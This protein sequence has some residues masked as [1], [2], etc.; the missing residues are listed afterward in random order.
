MFFNVLFMFFDLYSC[1]LCFVSFCA[2][3]LLLFCLCPIFVPVYRPLTPAGNPI[4]VNKYHH[5]HH[6]HFITPFL[7]TL[8]T[9][10]ADLRF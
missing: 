10:D 4:A 7:N 5:H 1:F 2:L 6:H 9:G 8:R 3:L